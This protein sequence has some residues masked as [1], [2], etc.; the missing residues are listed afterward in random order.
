MR[1]PS[2]RAWWASGRRPQTP[3]SSCAGEAVVVAAAV[4]LLFGLLLGL[5]LEQVGLARDLGRGVPVRL[6]VHLLGAAE[7]FLRLDLRPAPDAHGAILSQVIGLPAVFLAAMLPGLS[8]FVALVG[9]RGP[10]RSSLV[11]RCDAPGPVSLRGLGRLPRPGPLLA[12]SSLRCSRACQPSWPWSASAARSAPR[13]D[14]PG[15]VS[16]LRTGAG[17][18]RRRRV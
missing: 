8:A 11:P 18:R 7:Q 10:V 1:A 3:A 14:A 2:P 17:R 5:G 15:P 6:P 4:L 16:L 9:F 12:R 13:C